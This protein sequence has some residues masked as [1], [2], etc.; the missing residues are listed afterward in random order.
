M[1]QKTPNNPHDESEWIPIL[2][3]LTPDELRNLSH[4]IRIFIAIKNDFPVVINRPPGRPATGPGK[5]RHMGRHWRRDKINHRQDGT[6]FKV[7]GHW[8]GKGPISY[9][10]KMRRRRILLQEKQRLLEK[11]AKSS[12]SHHSRAKRALLRKSPERNYNVG[13]TRIPHTMEQRIR[14][15]KRLTLLMKKKGETITSL[16]KKIT[17]PVTE[18][19]VYMWT[20][21]R[22]IP[23]P[24][25]YDG[26]CKALHIVP[27][28]LPAGY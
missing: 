12:S 2:K 1:A 26:L 17:P 25:V 19:A 7:A 28:E 14:F 20:K 24:A 4:I 18:A 21:K 27:S 23:T 16:S 11:S 6:T 13:V 22:T 15:S 5:G 8:A 10:S 3:Q 9:A